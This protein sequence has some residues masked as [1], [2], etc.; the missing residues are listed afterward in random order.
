MSGEQLVEQDAQ[1]VDV[2][3][4]GDGLA[5]NLFRTGAVRRHGSGPQRRRGGEKARVVAQQ[6]GD[7]EV[8]QLRR[9]VFS[10]QDVGG[11]QIAVDHQ[12]LMRELDCGADAAEEPQ[13]LGRR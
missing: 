2:R 11:L 7:P 13:A 9:A 10:H 6:L 4:R 3:R 8:E 1:G 12:V 5:P